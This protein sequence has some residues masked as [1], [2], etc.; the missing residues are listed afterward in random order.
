MPARKIIRKSNAVRKLS[1]R[2]TINSIRK[3]NSATSK[4]QVEISNGIIVKPGEFRSVKN[5]LGKKIC[6]D[7]KKRK[8]NKLVNPINGRMI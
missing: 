5:A 2:K 3:L 1:G 6:K 4:R 7:N 8:G